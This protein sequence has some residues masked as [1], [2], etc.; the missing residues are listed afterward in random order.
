MKKWSIEN[1]A[2]D[3]HSDVRWKHLEWAGVTVTKGDNWLI[4]WWRPCCF[5]RWQCSRCS[6]FQPRGGLWNG[7]FI[8]PRFLSIKHSNDESRL[9]FLLQFSLGGRGEHFLRCK[10]AVYWSNNRVHCLHWLRWLSYYDRQSANREVK[11]MIKEESLRF[12]CFL[13]IVMLKCL[14]LW[15]CYS[16]TLNLFIGWVSELYKNTFVKFF[17]IDVD[18]RAM[19]ESKVH[20][21]NRMWLNFLVFNVFIF[22]NDQTMKAAVELSRSLKGIFFFRNF[23]LIELTKERNERRFLRGRRVRWCR[24]I[25]L[26]TMR[27]WLFAVVFA[28][29]AAGAGAVA[30]WGL[31][32]RLSRLGRLGRLCRLVWIGVCRFLN[33]NLKRDLEGVNLRMWENLRNLEKVR[34]FCKSEKFAKTDEIRENLQKFR[35]IFANLEIRVNL[36]IW[37]SEKISICKICKISKI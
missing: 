13:L 7:A 1:T 18:T 37:K 16:Y 3:E 22:W 28:A 19:S 12:H 32:G 14:S 2:D 17:F 24:V 9:I 11:L 15:K 10:W 21:M 34:K 25:C 8:T 26:Q 27:R 4:S 23:T 20:R 30:G 31:G 5:I 29:G 35:R 6:A 36:Q 33:L